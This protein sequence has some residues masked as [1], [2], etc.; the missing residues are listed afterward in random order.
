VTAA[1]PADALREQARVLAERVK[2][3]HCL[4]AIAR[5][6]DGPERDLDAVLAEIV[7]IVPRAWLHAD[8][9]AARIVVLDRAYGSARWRP[10]PPAVQHAPVVAHGEVVGALEVAYGDVQPERD[11]GPFLTEERSL[12]NAI[13]QRLGDIVERKWA[14]Q[15][16]REHEARLRS[17]AVELVRTEDRERRQIAEELHD[18]IGQTLASARIKIGM[19]VEEHPEGRLADDLRAVR[20][21]IAAAVAETRSLIFQISPPVLH[22]LGLGAALE[23]LTE[24]ARRQYGLEVRLERPAARL[25]LPDELR[26]ALFRGARELIANVARHARVA[27]AR[28][29]LSESGGV[30][31]VRVEDDGAGFDPEQ[32]RAGMLQ[33]GSF[34]LFGLRERIEQLGGR[35][36][37]ETAP[38][39]GARVTLSVPRGRGPVP[40]GGGA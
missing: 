37:I 2:E 3:L 18:R 5:T 40:A 29:T 33:T 34:G 24:E 19:L 23:W 8:C 13:A 31:Q 36:A 10:D 1:D 22:Q 30:V 39:R 9:A 14:A 11:E 6:L 7:E 20:E 35:L 15:R 32:V 16:L 28:M 21:L 17:L 38:G 26:S 12:L 4:Y 25:G 27:T